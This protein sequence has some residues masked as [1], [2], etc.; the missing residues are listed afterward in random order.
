MKVLVLIGLVAL[1]L[2][3]NDNIPKQGGLFDDET[4]NELRHSRLGK[5]ILQLA[6]LASLSQQFDFNQLFDAI[7]EV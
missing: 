3:L 5:T 1:T 7:D 2:A 6:E 4:S